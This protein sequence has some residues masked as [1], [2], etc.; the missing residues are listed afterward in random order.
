MFLKLPHVSLEEISICISLFVICTLAFSFVL[1]AFG[2]QELTHHI[3]KTK[4]LFLHCL[5]RAIYLNA[6]RLSL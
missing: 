3:R 5:L 1:S 2:S 4:F 6:Y